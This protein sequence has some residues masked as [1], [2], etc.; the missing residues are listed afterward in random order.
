MTNFNHVILLVGLFLIS[1]NS[2][3]QELNYYNSYEK[4]FFRFQDKN[5]SKIEVKEL[6]SNNVEAT[7]YFKKGLANETLSDIISLPASGYILYN[8]VNIDNTRTTF[9]PNW[10]LIGLSLGGVIFSLHL[11]KKS[12]ENFKKTVD[13][14]NGLTSVKKNFSL[15]FNLYTSK[16][17]VCINW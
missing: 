10:P 6:I 17:G 2:F 16:A 1:I 8:L 13:A 3:S 7:F 9:K 5:I 14:Y 11:N 15:S 4:D 12:K